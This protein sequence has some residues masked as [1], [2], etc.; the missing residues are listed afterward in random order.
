MRFLVTGATGFIGRHLVERLIAAGEQVKALVRPAADAT[1]LDA[2]GV[3]VIRGD[4]ADADAVQRA[5]K[6]CGVLFHLAA[7]TESVGLL[8]RDDVRVANIQG[9]E[10]VARAA[11]CADVERLVFSS[12][13][14][15]YGRIAK[16][17]LIDE[18]SE[19]N[20]DSPYGESKVRGEQIVLAARKQSGLPVVVA[21]I[22]TV[23]GPGTTSWLGLFRSIASGRFRLIGNGMNH[24]HIADVSDIVEGLLL[25][26]SKQGIE[27]RTY[28]LAGDESVPL[29]GLVE[30]IGEEVGVGRFPA[31]LPAT[32]LYVYRSLDRLV[33]A[34]TGHK[35]PR[36]DRLAMFLGDRTFDISRAK[37]QLE[38]NPKVKTK[39]T[40]HR[41]AEWFRA[42]GHLP[43]LG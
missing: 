32:P 25:C 28:T 39:D 8:S 35:L 36:A 20:P 2:H 11:L 38:Y 43:R 16:N 37:Q 21:R 10:N 34:L 4:I 22:A 23:W 17:R 14:A 15:V 27:G 40:I 30:M 42:Q 29:R 31:P 13:V 24:H 5:A 41:M 19:T 1:W 12:S 3:E 26:G 18:T 6:N 33:V 9:T 7:R